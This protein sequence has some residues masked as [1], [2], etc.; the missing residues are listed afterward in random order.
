MSNF[1]LNGI[2]GVMAQWCNPLTLQS[3]QSGAVGLIPGRAPPLEHHDKGSQTQL[4]LWY[5]VAIPAL[6]TKNH[7]FTCTFC[8]LQ[9]QACNLAQSLIASLTKL[10]SMGGILHSKTILGVQLRT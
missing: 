5:T 7:N 8:S 9:M 1:N 3:V 2:E 10:V 6:G 4:A